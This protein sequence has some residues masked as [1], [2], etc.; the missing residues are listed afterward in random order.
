MEHCREP[1]CRRD[2]ARDRSFAA[3]ASAQPHPEGVDHRRYGFGCLD[4]LSTG[5]ATQTV[6]LENR[7]EGPQKHNARIEFLEKQ[8][9]DNEK[10]WKEATKPAKRTSKAAVD[11]LAKAAKSIEDSKNSECATGRGNKCSILEHDL[12]TAISNLTTAQ[13]DKDATDNLVT[14]EKALSD[15]KDELKRLGPKIEHANELSVWTQF[16]ASL[17]VMSKETAKT[18][19]DFKPV[20]DTIAAELFGCGMTVPCILGWIWLFG[21]FTC[22]RGEADR[23]MAELGKDIAGDRAKIVLS[24]MSQ[25][26]V[27][28]FEAGE[29]ET[30][31]RNCEGAPLTP[32]PAFRFPMYDDSPQLPNT[33]PAES[34]GIVGE[35]MPRH[36]EHPETA[37]EALAAKMWKLDPDKPKEGRKV[38]GAKPAEP[39]ADSALDCCRLW[40]SRRHGRNT[41]KPKAYARYKK[42]CK[43]TN[44][45]PLKRLAFYAVVA[46]ELSVATKR[47]SGQSCFAD[48]GINDQPALRAVA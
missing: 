7:N 11:V 16:L 42:Y 6:A 29:K 2:H 24:A 32:K 48:M 12:A 9:K 36:M 15:D 19:T 43:D 33:P 28:D 5:T 14:I 31:S 34:L 21:L 39:H 47:V 27:D 41:P 1:V 46:K 4:D 18:L 10:A 23:R 22:T 40:F 3:W 45:L 35:D 25:S 37:A 20:T 8:I 13:A 44:V 38:R 17:H 26:A 30:P